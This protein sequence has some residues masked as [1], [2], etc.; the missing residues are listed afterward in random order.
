M[1]EITSGSRHQIK[2]ES[3]AEFLEY[4]EAHQGK[5]QF[6]SSFSGSGGIP[7]TVALARKGLS[8]AGLS[9]LNM[10][11]DLLPALDA[12]LVDTRFRPMMSTEG[13]EVDIAAFLDGEPECMVTYECIDQA[14][15]QPIVT[16]VIAVGVL[17]HVDT[18]AIQ[19]R[20]TQV[21]ALLQAIEYA[22]VQTEIWADSSTNGRN[23]LFGRISVRIKEAGKP[24]DAGTLMYA[25]THDSMHRTLNFNAKDH[26][27]KRFSDAM[28]RSCGYGSTA[29]GDIAHP[30][31][32]P[33]GAVYIR[34]L[35]NNRDTL[36]VEDTLR[37]L[38][39]MN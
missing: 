2:F 9:A 11:A 30:E 27:P 38:N 18:E 3:F 1:E 29:L 34:A 10:A 33:A 19:Q 8:A 13:A 31:D 25:M 16:I 4:Q 17:G 12:D 36:N 5:N 39:L 37:E 35:R 6:Q 21:M 26:F 7:A 32:Y 28:G 24:F 23:D 22:G 15:I 20:G 14:N